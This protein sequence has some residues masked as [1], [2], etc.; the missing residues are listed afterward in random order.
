MALEA[1]AS[2]I[3]NALIVEEMASLGLRALDV[4]IER[5]ELKA[6]NVTQKTECARVRVLIAELRQ[7]LARATLLV[8]PRHEDDDI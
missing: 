4:R 7:A 3:A 8:E 5:L 6:E 1:L 2:S